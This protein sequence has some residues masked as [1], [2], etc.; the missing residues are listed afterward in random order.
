MSSNRDGADVR[1]YF[2]WTLMDAFVW[3]SGYDLK[4]GL[5]SFDRVT[6]NRIP[7]LSAKWYRDFLRKTSLKDLESRS[8]IPAINQDGLVPNVKHGSADMAC[9]MIINLSF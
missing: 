2:I 5:Y 8:A 7:R 6:L 4:F 3:S 1:G 9:L